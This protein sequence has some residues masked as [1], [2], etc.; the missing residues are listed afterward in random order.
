[1]NVYFLYRLAKTINNIDI[2][3]INLVYIIQQVDF[4][5]FYL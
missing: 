2:Q 3:Y 1:M 4:Q 5:Q